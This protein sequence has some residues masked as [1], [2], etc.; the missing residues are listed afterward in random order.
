MVGTVAAMTTSTY[1]HKATSSADDKRAI[2]EKSGN[3]LPA[4]TEYTVPLDTSAAAATCVTGRPSAVSAASSFEATAWAA[5]T[6]GGAAES[7]VPELNSPSRS[8]T[9]GGGSFRRAM[10]TTLPHPRTTPTEEVHRVVTDPLSDL[11]SVHI[12]A[13]NQSNICS[14]TGYGMGIPH[15]LFDEPQLVV[16][17][18]ANLLAMQ[19]V[20]AT[21]RQYAD[22]L[23]APTKTR[24][25]QAYKGL[26]VVRA[27]LEAADWRDGVETA[28]RTLPRVGD[29]V[30]RA[31]VLSNGITVLRELPQGTVLADDDLDAADRQLDEGE[32]EVVQPGEYPRVL[33]RLPDGHACFL[34]V[35]PA[36]HVGGTDEPWMAG[37]LARHAMSGK[38]VR[39][40]AGSFIFCRR[41]A[42]SVHVTPERHAHPFGGCSV[43]GQVAR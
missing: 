16:P 42:P 38:Y 20:A 40:F 21:T 34:E 30:D 9:R 6:A 2:T 5:T 18:L 1:G 39:R 14:T 7:S 13:Q 32:R 17:V 19:P 8:H 25:R 33:V 23:E 10:P 12:I 3:D 36:T 35:H 22:R 29:R 4:S 15:E 24:R 31:E 26:R 27:G 41:G 28:M 43:C 37:R 11:T